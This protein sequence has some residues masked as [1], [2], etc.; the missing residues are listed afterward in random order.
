M[1]KRLNQNKLHG[2]NGVRVL[3]AT[4]SLSLAAL[5]CTTNQYPSAGEP[6]TAPPAGGSVAPSLSTTPGSAGPAIPSTMI[7][8]AVD[9]GLDAVAILEANRGY[10][11][12]VLGPAAPGPGPSMSLRQATNQYISPSLY[13]NPQ[14]TINSSVSSQPVPAIVSGAAVGGAAVVATPGAGLFANTIVNPSLP[15]IGN[16]ATT[17]GAN[18][19]FGVTGVSNTTATGLTNSTTA[20]TNLASGTNQVVSTGLA[21]APSSASSVLATR[22]LGTSGRLNV[23][24][25][26]IAPTSASPVR[27]ETTGGRVTVTNAG[28]SNP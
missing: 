26:A 23:D 27:V 12:R 1:S 5:G 20:S 6:V 16:A 14:Q 15:S 19:N 28:T 10:Q 21:A 22:T 4:L 3:V 7:S 11:G 25:T 9:P 8:A 13:A 17:V 2:R 24:N 18:A